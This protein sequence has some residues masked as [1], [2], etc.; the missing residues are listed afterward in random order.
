MKDPIG[1]EQ[2]ARRRED[3]VGRNAVVRVVVTFDMANEE[4][5]WEKAKNR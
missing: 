5:Q 3:E 4:K 1:L 2:E